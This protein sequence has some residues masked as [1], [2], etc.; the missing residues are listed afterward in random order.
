MIV[1]IKHLYTYINTFIHIHFSLFFIASIRHIDIVEN[2][3]LHYYK[4]HRDAILSASVDPISPVFI[5]SAADSLTCFWDFR[6]PQEL[7]RIHSGASPIS[8][9]SRDGGIIAIVTQTRDA[10]KYRWSSNKRT[11]FKVGPVGFDVTLYDPRALA[12]PLDSITLAMP[13]NVLGGKVEDCVSMKFSN[14]G[15]N[16]L[17]TTNTHSLYLVSTRFDRNIPVKRLTDDMFINEGNVLQA[18]FTYDDKFVVCG[19]D[20]DDIFVWDTSS[21]YSLSKS[22]DVIDIKRGHSSVVA[23]N[24]IYKMMATAGTD[25]SLWLPR[26]DQDTSADSMDDDVSMDQMN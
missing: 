2:K 22:T 6:T 5:S 24:P 12:K 14:T 23:F 7:Y 17:I 13:V 25:L 15:R 1:S 9:I 4:G 8:S 20:G 16:I 18:D 3:I 11:S 19:S 21:E 26:K 10:K